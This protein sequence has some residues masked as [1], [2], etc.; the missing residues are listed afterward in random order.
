MLDTAD[1]LAEAEARAVRA[2]A[3]AQA[4][5]RQAEAADEGNQLT[6]ADAVAADT[7]GTDTVAAGTAAETRRRL[8]LLGRKGLLRRQVLASAAALAVACASLTASGYLLWQHHNVEQHRQ[9]AAEFSAAARGAVEAMMSLDAKTARADW[10]R[11]ADDTTGQF[12]AMVLIGGED[13]VKT[14]EQSKMTSKGS[15]LKAAVQS[16]TNDS[17]V[18]LVAAKLELSKA[19]QPKPQSQTTRM[20]VTVEKD[21]GQ[22]KVSRVEGVP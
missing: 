20:V 7:A 2:R 5:R 21:G 3:R 10:Q 13:V 19:D 4:L 18:V 12:K 6:V 9:R 15:V 8:R 11:F 14:V 22:L 17:A 16:M 1:E